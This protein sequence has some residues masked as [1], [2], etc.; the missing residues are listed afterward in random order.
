MPMGRLPKVST[1]MDNTNLSDEVYTGDQYEYRTIGASGDL[2]LSCN[3]LGGVGWQVC[4]VSSGAPHPIT[5]EA[6][7][8]LLVMRKKTLVIVAGA[9]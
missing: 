4:A 3:T 8:Q 5:G 6:V 2:V 1:V 7:F 9:S